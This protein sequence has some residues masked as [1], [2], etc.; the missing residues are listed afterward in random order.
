M[1]IAPLRD[2]MGSHRGEY[3]SLTVATPALDTRFTVLFN[4]SVFLVLN[5]RNLLVVQ[6][7]MT[8]IVHWVSDC[9][10]IITGRYK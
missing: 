8:A 2:Q 6:T 7:P 1:A 10:K 3:N 5:H 9:K 4:Q